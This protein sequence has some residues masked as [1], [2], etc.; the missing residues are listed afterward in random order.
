MI[1]GSGIDVIEI[2]RIEQALD[3]RGE[4]FER[5]IYTPREIESCRRALR[6][7]PHFAVRFAAKEAVMK[8]VGTGWAKGVR[9]VDIETVPEGPVEEASS[10]IS[11]RLRLVLHGRVAAIAEERGGLTAHLAVSRSR[12]HAMAVVLLEGADG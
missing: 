4:R 7:A 2:A 12:S 9:W 11:D 6:T 1:I 3:R 8:A 10:A 5:R